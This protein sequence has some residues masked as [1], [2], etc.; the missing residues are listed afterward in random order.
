MYSDYNGRPK[1]EASV[2]H[3]DYHAERGIY[4]VEGKIY[5]SS[6][7]VN[8]SAQGS[9]IGTK[10]FAT[11]VQ[12]GI[13][14]GFKSI[15]TYAAKGSSYNGFYTWPRLGYDAPLPGS[16]REKLVVGKL[17]KDAEKFSR[18]SDVMKSKEGR[19]WWK[20]NGTQ[21]NMEFDLS[22]GSLSRQVLGAYARAKGIANDI[23][24]GF[25]KQGE[26]AGRRVGAG[27]GAGRGAGEDPKRRA[28][29]L[30]R[31]RAR[32]MA[33][34]ARKS[35]AV[36]IA[37]TLGYTSL[38]HYP[39]I[40]LDV[41]NS[42]AGA[43]CGIGAGGFQPGNTC[44]KGGGATTPTGT[45]TGATGVK[46]PKPTR[47][48]ES[49]YHEKFVRKHF[50]LEPEDV[51][52]LTGALPGALVRWGMTGGI[53]G[54]DAVVE[55]H[56][57]HKEYEATYQMY[58]D[59]L[60]IEYMRSYKT[61]GGLG[62]KVLGNQIDAAIDRGM[63]N[64]VLVAARNDNPDPMKRMN[65]YH[66]WPRYGFDSEIENAAIS[67]GQLDTYNE[68]R[69]KAPPEIQG[70]LNTKHARISDL[71]K[72]KQGREWWKENGFSNVSSFDLSEDSLSRRVWDAYRAE[73]ESRGVGHNARGR[74]D[75]RFDLGSNRGGGPSQT[76]PARAKYHWVSLETNVFCATG[77][78]GGV[79]ATCSPIFGGAKPF[80][81]KAGDVSRPRRLRK[82]ARAKWYA[83]Q[84]TKRFAKRFGM[85]GNPLTTPATNDLW[86]PV[87][88]AFCPTGKGGGIDP[89]CSPGSG[90]KAP[91]GSGGKAPSLDGSAEA[92]KKQIHDLA[93][94]DEIQLTIKK[95][96]PD[97]DQTLIVP[98]GD[99]RPSDLVV[100]ESVFDMSVKAASAI[101]LGSRMKMAGLEYKEASAFLSHAT[102]SE[103]YY[104]LFWEMDDN[105]RK[106]T[107]ERV[108]AVLLSSW[109]DSSGNND[110]S[111]AMQQKAKEVFHIDNTF[112]RRV[113]PGGRVVM[114]D[115]SKVIEIGLK[116]IYDRAQQKME[117]AGVPEVVTLYRGSSSPKGTLVKRSP[118]SPGEPEPEAHEVYPDRP[119][120]LQPLSS[121]SRSY[122]IA[123]QFSTGQGDDAG[124]MAINVPR[125]K[126]F[127]VPGTGF[128]CLHENEYVVMGGDYNARV[129]GRNRGEPL[130]KEKF[131]E[132]S[133]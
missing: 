113:S 58:P 128:G 7:R 78:G 70:I 65:G 132:S 36:A 43:N 34:I 6:L 20:A 96:F 33:R 67:S 42:A 104:D 2:S 115:H 101:E 91:G 44:A 77:E 133:P 38:N 68:K 76:S 90:G 28:Q 112:D 30:A 45:A 107:W 84:R 127:S 60:Q 13:K 53:E 111:I 26:G 88:N 47:I 3:A 8:N 102:K 64:I 49:E 75:P 86:V 11:Q 114:E 5:N 100:T 131:W 17:L 71:M 12:A 1:V 14:A 40:P 105:K 15:N 73:K 123:A 16:V 9:G 118:G 52:E 106:D 98:H 121:F 55:V 93:K 117:E 56:V 57:E 25:R 97:E 80:A 46:P 27:R 126:I 19:D 130:T 22:P 124:V 29:R 35:S 10:I 4:P 41:Y 83:K 74:R 110:V 79:K 94:S 18:I 62:A 95:F 21:G 87:F 89:T 50:G 122:D 48:E 63:D 23:D 85:P 125:S 120:K 119:V 92:L 103:A 32:R 69:R 66:S 129:Y 109:A 51:I 59:H 108:A 54:G 24:K 99:R 116:A 82:D 81:Y 31:R 37:N 72:S 39:W 61:G